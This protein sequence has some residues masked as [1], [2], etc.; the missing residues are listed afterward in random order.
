MGAARPR[1]PRRIHICVEAPRP[2]S[3]GCNRDDLQ[4]ANGRLGGHRQRTFDGP[5]IIAKFQD[6]AA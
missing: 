3:A 4:V 5:T 6:A 1:F 2:G